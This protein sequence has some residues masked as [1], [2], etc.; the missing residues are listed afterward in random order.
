MLKPGTV[1]VLLSEAD[2]GPRRKRTAVNHGIVSAW[3]R[4][5]TLCHRSGDVGVK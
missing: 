1:G 3:F 2:V 5:Q 4:S